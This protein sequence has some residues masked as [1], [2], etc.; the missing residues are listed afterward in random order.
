M[1][2]VLAIIFLASLSSYAKNSIDGLV[3]DNLNQTNEKVEIQEERSKIEL[4]KHKRDV[5]PQPDAKINPAE[6]HG[7]VM[8]P[9]ASDTSDLQQP[10]HFTDLEDPASS[11]TREV[12]AEKDDA[13]ERDLQKKELIKAIK[14][15]AKKE[16]VD[17]KIN[18][19]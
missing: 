1:R 16:G 8:P 10:L 12:S 14:A 19:E 3:N 5:V 6:S 11:I 4:Q 17:V 13:L 9:D 18:D 2:H 7:V 15:K